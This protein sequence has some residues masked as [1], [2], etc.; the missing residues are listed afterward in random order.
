LIAT[1]A[2]RDLASEPL[3]GPSQPCSGRLD[4]NTQPFRSYAHALVETQQS[5]ADNCGTR[6]EKRRE[7][8]G[9]ECPN[10]VTGKRLSRAI[11]YLA[12]DSQDLPMS[13][14]SDEVRPT[15]GGFGFRQ[16]L[17]RYCPQ[18][19]AITLDQ[20]QVGSDND[21]GLAE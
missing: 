1:F 21:F 19:Y 5:E 7:V 13:R 4:G 12:R 18:Q 6:Y 14:S 11:D 17:E 16:L 8:D 15:V 3:I 9:I 20:G 2:R 10:R